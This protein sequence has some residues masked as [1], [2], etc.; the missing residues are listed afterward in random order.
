MGK[1]QNNCIKIYG[2]QNYLVGMKNNSNKH[3]Q[4]LEINLKVN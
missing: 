3:K 2:G 4:T 1:Q